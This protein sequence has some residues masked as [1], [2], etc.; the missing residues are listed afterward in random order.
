MDGPA[1]SDERRR[2]GH[3]GLVNL[4]EGCPVYAG[5][6]S[7]PFTAVHIAIVLSPFLALPIVGWLGG[8][9]TR[10]SVVP[11]LL[12]AGL[13]AYFAYSLAVVQRSGPFSL[14]ARWAPALNL[15][16]S[17]RFD[18]LGLVFAILIAGVGTLVVLYSAKYYD[19]HPEAGRFYVTLFAFMGAMLG[20]VLSDNAIALFVFWELTGFTSYLLIG[21]EH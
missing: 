18:G 21:F 19:H 4:R 7:L 9:G 13:T 11:A 8:R 20:L 3:D 10:R 5:L 17:F 6:T 12:P 1:G 2:A 16:L 14:S 15:S